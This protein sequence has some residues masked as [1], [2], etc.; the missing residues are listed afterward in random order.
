MLTS[1]SRAGPRRALRSSCLI[2]SC[3]VAIVCLRFVAIAAPALRA[4]APTRCMPD[5]ANPGQRASAPPTSGPAELAAQP[6]GLRGGVEARARTLL[7]GRP[8][9]RKPS[10]GPLSRRASPPRAPPSRC[11]PARPEGIS[12]SPPTWARSPSRSAC[13]QGSSTAKPI[14]DALET[15]LR[16]DPA[17]HERLGRSRARPLVFQGAGPVRRQQQAIGSAPAQVATYNPNSIISHFF[18]A[19]TLLDVGRKDEARTELQKVLDAPLDP[20]WA[21]ED[22]RL[23]ASERAKP[24]AGAIGS[25]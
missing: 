21:P 7:A 24:L 11:E 4:D 20:D 18:L 8:R 5:R 25:R 14:K 17:F 13:A 9:R 10:G 19:E 3:I 6:D 23:Q 22:R 15:V 2:R 12:G 1:P 16:L